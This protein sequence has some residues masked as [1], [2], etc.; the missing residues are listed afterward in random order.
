MICLSP[1]LISTSVT[2]N[3]QHK[4]PVVM[5]VSM[6]SKFGLT[7]SKLPSTQLVP[8][9]LPFLTQFLLSGSNKPFTHYRLCSLYSS[10]NRLKNN[11]PSF[12]KWRMLFLFTKKA[13][14][15]QKRPQLI[16]VQYIPHQ[17]DQQNFRKIIPTPSTTLLIRQCSH[18]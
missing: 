9:N 1:L 6:T 5:H 18:I 4:H 11:L 10:T 2:F 3:S 12:G 16:A 13:S 8:I 14:D 15:L 17:S 7:T